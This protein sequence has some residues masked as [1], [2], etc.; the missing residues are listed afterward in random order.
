MQSFGKPFRVYIERESVSGAVF[1]KTGLMCPV[2]WILGRG[3]NH[4]KSKNIAYKSDIYKVLSL[5]GSGI[6]IGI[7]PLKFLIHVIAEA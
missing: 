5:Y 3:S 4:Q 6:D 7:G 1:L 2:H